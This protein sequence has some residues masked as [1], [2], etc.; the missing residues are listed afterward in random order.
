MARRSS[1]DV[2]AEANANIRRLS[3]L[4]PGDKAL[5]P[6]SPD[7]FDGPVR[8]AAPRPI[9]PTRAT[10]AVADKRFCSPMTRLER[11]DRFDRHQGA[12]RGNGVQKSERA[13][14]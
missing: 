2:A 9:F 11:A 5:L 8:K 3:M 13:A 6:R 7:A 4:G 14:R 10:G 1:C 12:A